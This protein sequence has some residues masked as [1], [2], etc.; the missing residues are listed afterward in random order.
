M[1]WR[2][3]GWLTLIYLLIGALY[4]A[5]MI[6]TMGFLSPS[7]VDWSYVPIHALV[8]LWIMMTPYCFIVLL[9]FTVLAPIG[10]FYRA[11][12]RPSRSLLSVYAC[13]TFVVIT[14]TIGSAS[15]LYIAGNV[16]LSK[17]SWVNY[18]LG[19]VLAYLIFSVPFAAPA[20]AAIVAVMLPASHPRGV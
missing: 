14:V 1:I 15:F 4:L 9:L 11:M 5:F 19:D 12:N 7:R 8:P 17:H 6:P 10:F 13:G 18:T 3:F 2:I 16:P 20:F